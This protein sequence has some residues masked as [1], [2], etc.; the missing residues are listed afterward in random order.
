MPSFNPTKTLESENLLLRKLSKDDFDT[1]YT[2]M[3][4]ANIW[5]GHPRRDQY[6]PEARK[7]WFEKALNKLALVIIDKHT[8]QIIGSSRY[9]ETDSN[10]NE[11][12][13][14][15]TFL[16]TKHWGGATNRELKEL[17]FKHAWEHFDNVWLHIAKE[18]IRSRKAAKKIGAQLDHIGIKHG[19]PYCW[20]LLPK[21]AI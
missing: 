8:N 18:N 3:A 19:L 4:D 2:A 9:Y 12:S 13:I 11:T 1:I 15:Y 6:K 20:Y 16:I 7:Q 14:G 17:M 21:G 10:R 5:A